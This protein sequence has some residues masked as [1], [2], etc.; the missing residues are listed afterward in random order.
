MIG[1]GDQQGHA[2]S[3]HRE[4]RDGADAR[5]WKRAS[6][7]SSAIAVTS[8]LGKR[9]PSSPVE[10]E[11]REGQERDQPEMEKRFVHS[12]IRSMRSTASVAR[13]RN[14]AMMMARPTAASA[15]AT[16]ITKKTKIWPFTCVPLM[17]EGDE[18]E[19]HGVEHELDGHED[20]DEI[21]LDEEADDAEAEE[22]GAKEQIPGQA[23]LP[24]RRGALDSFGRLPSFCIA[25]AGERN[26][27]ENGDE[28]QDRCDFEGQQQLG[29]QTALRSAVLVM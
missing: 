9:R 12:F 15:A 1:S 29:E 21:A 23:G 6:G 11:I 19:V 24:E 4:K 26:G 3:E 5:Q 10:Q 17:G 27:A 14:T 2:R 18:G 8:D 22:D 20:R 16:T 25:F 13:A 7:A 28:D